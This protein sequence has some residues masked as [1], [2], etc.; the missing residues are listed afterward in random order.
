VENIQERILAKMNSIRT[1]RR[2]IRVKE[3]ADLIE[4][5]TA[6][7]NWPVG[8]FLRIVGGYRR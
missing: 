6:S 8:R 1:K 5:R 3:N 7:Q 4:V 2:R